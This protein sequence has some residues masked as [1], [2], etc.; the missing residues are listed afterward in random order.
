MIKKFGLLASALTVSASVAA[1]AAA[2]PAS[3]AH[4]ATARPA[5]TVRQTRATAPKPGPTSLNQPTQYTYSVPGYGATGA[6]WAQ[7]TATTTLAKDVGQFSSSYQPFISVYNDTTSPEVELIPISSGGTPVDAWNPNADLGGADVNGGFYWVQPKPYPANSACAGNTDPR[8]CFYAGETVTLTVSYNTGLHRA[9]MT[10]EDKANGDEYSASSSYS[11]AQELTS[12]HIGD[13]WLK[14]FPSGGTFTPAAR[15]K[16]LG[17]FSAV[18]L[19]DTS[20]RTKP[21]G[22]W[23]HYQRI[24][25]SNATAKGQVDVYPGPLAFNGQKFSLYVR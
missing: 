1:V 5:N 17:T 6:D 23:P 3:A 8:G 24:M 2:V 13:I 20:G 11:S 7:A 18:T 9:Y 22:S 25:T 15:T 19:T 21:L 10:I 14:T 4:Q 16:E 12:V